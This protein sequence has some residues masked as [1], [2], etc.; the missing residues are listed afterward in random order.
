[1]RFI[2]SE[3]LDRILLVHGDLLQQDADALVITTST[4]LTGVGE[5]GRQLLDRAGTALMERL[6]LA[7]PVPIGQTFET[8]VD[9]LPGRRLI[10]T[11]VGPGPREDMTLESLLAGLR[12]ALSAADRLDGVT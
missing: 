12:A 2:V 1:Q 4:T 9:Q 5:V 10:F 3:A 6:R 7:S 11:P 8:L